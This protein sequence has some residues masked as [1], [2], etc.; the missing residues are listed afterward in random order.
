MSVP[1]SQPGLFG[2]RD[3][4]TASPKAAA[5]PVHDISDVPLRPARSRGADK[6]RHGT[7]AAAHHSQEAAAFQGEVRVEH[8]YRGG[9]LARHM[10]A[11]TPAE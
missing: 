9:V 7:N 5:M 4:R 8:D 2:T 3:P 6:P 1:A 10:A 11:L